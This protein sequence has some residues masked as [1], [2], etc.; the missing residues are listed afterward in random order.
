[1]ANMHLDRRSRLLTELSEN[2]HLLL[3]SLD[4]ETRNY[5]DKAATDESRRLFDKVRS[6][7][8]QIQANKRFCA[9]ERPGQAAL[10]A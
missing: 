3:Q 4:T 2:V 7:S 1:M 6:L 10:F 5:H 8:D 9:G